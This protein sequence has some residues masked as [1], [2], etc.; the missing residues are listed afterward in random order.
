M[1]RIYNP[2]E[3]EERLYQ[4]WEERGYFRPETQVEKGRADVDG[5]R[6]CITMPPP[7]V[8]G[9]LHLGHAMTAAVEDLMTRYHR[10]RGFETLFLPGSDHAGI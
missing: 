10:M 2:R 3:I 6:F 1:A 5:P 8:T 9:A 4:W 7:N